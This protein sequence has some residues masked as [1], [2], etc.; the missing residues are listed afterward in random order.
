V[1]FR[2]FFF[3]RGYGAPFVKRLM[4]KITATFFHIELQTM[5]IHF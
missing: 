3:R 4:L 1:T 2:R 5:L